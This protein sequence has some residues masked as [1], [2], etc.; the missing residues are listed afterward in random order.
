LHGE[1]NGTVT[2]K[3]ALILSTCYSNKSSDKRKQATTSSL[4][5]RIS[6]TYQNI[7]K[8]KWC[9]SRLKNQQIPAG[10]F[11]YLAA[12]SDICRYHP[13]INEILTCHMEYTESLPPPPGTHEACRLPQRLAY[14]ARVC[15]ALAWPGRTESRPV[16]CRPTWPLAN[17]GWTRSCSII[18]FWCDRARSMLEHG[19]NFLLEDD[20]VHHWALGLVTVA[21]LGSMVSEELRYVWLR[22]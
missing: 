8:F 19:P 1:R 4:S 16:I 9:G 22:R 5:T 6:K 3:Q 15:L 10:I 18:N 17:T 21:R 13:H 12:S 20:R 2:S 11:R 14:E 7:I